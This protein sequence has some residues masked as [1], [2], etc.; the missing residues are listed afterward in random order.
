MDAC[1]PLASPLGPRRPILVTSV[2]WLATALLVSTAPAQQNGNQTLTNLAPSELPGNV[3]NASGRPEYVKTKR[4][5]ERIL[6]KQPREVVILPSEPRSFDE[7][8]TDR[9][10]GTIGEVQPP[11]KHLPEGY[12][13]AGRRATA[14]RDGKWHVLVLEPRPGFPP[15]PPLRVLP[16]RRLMMLEA[17]LQAR[18]EPPVFLATGRITEFLD[19]NYILLEHLAE[20]PAIAPEVP[21]PEAAPLAP[22]P[23]SPSPSGPT[24]TGELA[25]RVDEPASDEGAGGE[26]RPEDII[27][28]LLKDKPKR[29]VVLPDQMPAAEPPPSTSTDAQAIEDPDQQRQAN[30]NLPPEI[31]MPVEAEMD[32]S[33]TGGPAWPE[34]TMLVDRVGRVLPGEDYW[35]FAFEDHGLNPVD[36]PIRLLPSR[37]LENA[38]SMGAGG[39]SHGTV[40][41]VSGE[42]TEYR[43]TNYLLI[44][45]VLLRPEYGNLR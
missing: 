11:T 38:I 15:S 20:A 23:E 14:K 17:V 3:D 8:I 30:A 41:V 42:V 12:V 4:V 26:L 34:E 29:A 33:G 2:L 9:S 21:E 45:K 40:F 6:S 1:T 13:I 37:L 25:E 5:P 10:G 39:E 19:G 27:E 31:Q 7:E 24:G 16:N 36:R 43:R 35:V 22:Q 44:R 28:G 32:R 18:S